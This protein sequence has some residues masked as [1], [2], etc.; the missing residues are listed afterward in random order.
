MPDPRRGSPPIPRLSW[1][2][3]P[4]AG[5]PSSTARAGAGGIR[6]RVEWP[7]LPFGHG[8]EDLVGDRRDRLPRDLGAV[9]LG[10]VRLH[11]AG[12]QAFRGQGDDQFVDPGEAF[13]RLATI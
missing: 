6:G 4:G 5:G 13:L 8:V 3:P 7:V 12:R 9:D 10:Q 2:S 1:N 11:L